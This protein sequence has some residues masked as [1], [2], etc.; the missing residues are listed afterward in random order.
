MEWIVHPFWL[1]W[2]EMK[3]LCRFQICYNRVD[4]KW[5]AQDHRLTATSIHRSH[6]SFPLSDPT[7]W[8]P[9]PLSSL[10][11]NQTDSITRFVNGWS[12]IIDLLLATWLWLVYSSFHLYRYRLEVS[13]FSED[14]SPRH[15]TREP[16]GQQQ[17]LAQSASNL[18]EL[19]PSQLPWCVD[20]CL[21]R[22]LFVNVID[23]WFRIGARGGGRR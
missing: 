5:F 17:L 14:P 8:V 12:V 21:W 9:P 6:Q 7:R 20:W 15:Q 23:M 4:A 10:P 19:Q 16:I 1:D 2:I 13:A 18:P 3:C 11:T 22:F